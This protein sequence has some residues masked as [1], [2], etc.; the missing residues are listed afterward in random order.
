MDKS[1]GAS[2]EEHMNIRGIRGVSEVGGG[3]ES[4][5]TLLAWE[6]KG[7]KENRRVC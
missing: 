6:M 1:F 7:L 4:G 2:L 3:G 5:K